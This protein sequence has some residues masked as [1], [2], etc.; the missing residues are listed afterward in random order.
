MS[1]GIVWSSWLLAAGHESAGNICEAIRKS[2]MQSEMIQTEI[3]GER[4]NMRIL[5]R[6]RRV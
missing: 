1:R 6:S 2:G 5:A 3:N 4:E